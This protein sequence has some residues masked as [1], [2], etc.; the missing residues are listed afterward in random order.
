[1]VQF[2]ISV[3]WGSYFKI[4]K[5]LTPQPRPAV[6]A[7]SL[8]MFQAAWVVV[9]LWNKGVNSVLLLAS[10]G[11]CSN[12]KLLVEYKDGLACYLIARCG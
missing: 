4:G 1:M 3:M 2:D 6:H 8:C 11:G 10:Q 7:A 12:T 9:S 5:C